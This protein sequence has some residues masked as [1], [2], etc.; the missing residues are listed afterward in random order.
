MW[1]EPGYP[2][3]MMMWYGGGGTLRQ[4]IAKFETDPAER[5]K[6]LEEALAYISE[7]KGIAE[8]L[9]PF[10]YWNIGIGRSSLGN[11]EY[12]LAEVTEDSEKK[13]GLLGA[14]VAD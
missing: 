12:D 10:L 14:A 13:K 9:E 2:E 8:R 5:R 1:E 6:G 4:R 11:I 7:S 3:I